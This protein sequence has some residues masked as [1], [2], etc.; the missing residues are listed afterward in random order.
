[1]GDWGY[2]GDTVAS[3]MMLHAWR[4]VL[5][6]SEGRIITV[7]APSPFPSLTNVIDEIPRSVDVTPTITAAADPGNDVHTVAP[8][9]I[10][11]YES[12]GVLPYSFINGRLHI[13]L[14][15]QL[16]KRAP[17]AMTKGRSKDDSNTNTEH[18]NVAIN[19]SE[20]GTNIDDDKHEIKVETD[21]EELGFCW[22]VMND[23]RRLTN[24]DACDTAARV[25]GRELLYLWSPPHLLHDEPSAR[26]AALSSDFPLPSFSS[27]LPIGQSTAVSSSSTSSPALPGP[28]SSTIAR[29]VRA[30]T[31]EGRPNL[32]GVYQYARMLRRPSRITLNKELT[33]TSSASSTISPVQTSPSTGGIASSSVVWIDLRS[34]EERNRLAISTINDTSDG[35]DDKG[36]DDDDD[37]KAAPSTLTMTSER[38][39]CQMT[40]S[41]SAKTNAT[42]IWPHVLFISPMMP[43]SS[44]I[45]NYARWKHTNSSSLS[46]PTP[47]HPP[48]S[49]AS[50]AS[51]SGSDVKANPPKGQHNHIKATPVYN[52]NGTISLPAAP[53]TS[54]DTSD[55]VNVTISAKLKK[56]LKKENYLAKKAAHQP[57]ATTPTPTPAVVSSSLVTTSATATAEQAS[58]ITVIS[59]PN[60]PSSPLTGTESKVTSDKRVESKGNLKG[61]GKKNKK[62]NNIKSDNRADILLGNPYEVELSSLI[63]GRTGVGPGIGGFGQRRI[64]LNTSELRWLPIDLLL[65]DHNA[66]TFWDH[67]HASPLTREPV[68]AVNFTRSQA[69]AAGSGVQT[70][71]CVICQ[72]HL[73]LGV[74]I[75]DGRIV[76]VVQDP[77]WHPNKRSK[78][79]KKSDVSSSSSGI[80]L[81]G[82]GEPVWRSHRAKRKKFELIELDDA[83]SNALRVPSFVGTLR[84]LATTNASSMLPPSLSPPLRVTTNTSPAGFYDGIPIIDVPIVACATR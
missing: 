16:K 50:D 14:A 80:M 46:V 60:P 10:C 17:R 1:V 34:E 53:P 71:K 5:P 36:D 67:V 69:P 11:Q 65:S 62:S 73:P 3:R 77:L 43:I 26:P 32:H 47:S 49:T 42:G 25:L 70:C 29:R 20:S 37:T 81:M 8:S 51:L 12:S 72:Q 33:A 22:G 19:S 23:R 59:T 48:P 40:L 66:S 28:S 63:N 52:S 4:L 61:K 54:V 9:M 7:E 30:P 24:N 75:L 56:Q 83:L 79:N 45:L 6:L 41:S 58:S 68:A 82:N 38:K 18:S 55:N 64:P 31:H 39:H 13:L 57:V 2:C 21:E 78:A 76:I 35:L 74:Q 27:T 15:R 44:D 84:H